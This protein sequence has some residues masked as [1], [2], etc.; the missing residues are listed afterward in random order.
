MQQAFLRA[1]VLPLHSAGLVLVLVRTLDNSCQP[2]RVSAF[3]ALRL[4]TSKGVV[5]SKQAE[6]NL[7]LL[8][9]LR[10]LASFANL[11]F[12]RCFVCGEAK[13]LLDSKAAYKTYLQR[14]AVHLL[15][16]YSSLNFC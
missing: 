16:A 7:L 8:C 12:L 9:G 5:D 6:A 2:A 4:I 11:M 14:H 15:C 1:A 10:P 3:H 13:L